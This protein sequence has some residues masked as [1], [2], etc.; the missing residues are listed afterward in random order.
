M[1]RPLLKLLHPDCSAIENF[2]SLMGLTNIA[3]M[4]ESARKRILKEKGLSLIENYMFEHHEM[5]RR[6]AIQV[7]VCVRVC[8]RLYSFNKT[9]ENHRILM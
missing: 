8:V 4:S 6:A 9:L 7:S 5:I 2:E 1:V 3:G